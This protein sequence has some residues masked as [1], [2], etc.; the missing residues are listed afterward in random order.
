MGVLLFL[1]PITFGLALCGLAAFLWT[2]KNK[3]YDDIEGSAN[4]ILF[5]NEGKED[6]F[7]DKKRK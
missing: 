4:R 3:Q 1:I 6:N 5:D 2:I 7:S